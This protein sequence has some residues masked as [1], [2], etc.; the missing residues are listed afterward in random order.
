MKNIHILETDKPTRLHWYTYGEFGLSKKHLTWKEGRS[1]YITSDEEIK[2][3]DWYLTS[4]HKI[5]K[6]KKVL[7][8]IIYA[9]GDYGRNPNGCKKIILTTDQDLIGARF[10]N[11]EFLEWFIENPSCEYVKTYPLGDNKYGMVIPQVAHKEEPSQV[12][13]EQAVRPLMKWLSENSN[14]HATAI[15]T[16]RLA[17][18]VEGM[19]VFKTDEFLID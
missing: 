9:E 13:F 2:E 5:L 7:M 10:A 12:T 8:S 15:V 4:D 17:E 3:G 6:C 14:P 1:I 11:D 16:C 18:L 19:K